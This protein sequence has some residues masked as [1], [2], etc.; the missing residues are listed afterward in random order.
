MKK[1]LMAVVALGCL[2]A[3]A[4]VHGQMGMM[5][6][7]MGMMGGSAL[8]HQFVAQNG[9]DPKYANK[10][11]PLRATAANLAAGEKLYQ[12]DCAS[13]HGA[14]GFGDGPAAKSLNPPPA[15]IAASARMPMTSDGYLYWTI[16]EGGVPLHTA[17]PPF[18]SALTDEEIWKI[19]LYVRRL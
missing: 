16:A 13:C 9:I 2:I 15:N 10:S 12:A 8:R 5:G 3:A 6:R 14:T 11:N 7:G 17:M 19:I 1:K 4:S 18:K